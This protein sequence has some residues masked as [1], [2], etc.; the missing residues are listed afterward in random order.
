[1]RELSGKCDARL[2][3]GDLDGAVTV[4]RTLIEAVLG[5]LEER[6]AGQRGDYKGDLPKQFKAVGK[7][8][9][10]DDERPDLDDRFKD[11]VRGL[12]T[13]VSGL[14][15]LRNRIGDGHARTRRPAPHHV[16]VVVNA[17]RTIAIFLVESFNYQRTRK[18]TPRTSA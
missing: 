11:V 3:S 10:M 12:V 5:E 15:P 9:K 13:V 16:R 18:P 6:V 8:L 1:V 4:A 7:L 17:A 14:A 2:A